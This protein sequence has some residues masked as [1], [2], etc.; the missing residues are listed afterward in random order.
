M[1]LDDVDIRLLEA[2]QRDGRAGW[3]ELGRTVAPRHV[4]AGCEAEGSAAWWQ[5][6]LADARQVSQGATPVASGE[7]PDVGPAGDAS[8]DDI[9]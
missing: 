2:L 6:R 4:L 9:T 7:Q 1:A 8:A 3:A 5:A